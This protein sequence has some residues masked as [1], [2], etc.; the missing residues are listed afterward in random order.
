MIQINIFI[1][2]PFWNGFI[3]PRKKTHLFFMSKT[4][5]GALLINFVVYYSKHTQR[6]EIKS[7]KTKSI[8]LLKLFFARQIKSMWN[9]QILIFV[10]I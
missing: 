3:A 5:D 7:V 2:I 10:I 1:P 4:P 9:L 8:F 6:T